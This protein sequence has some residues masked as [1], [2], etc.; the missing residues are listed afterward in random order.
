M[1]PNVVRTMRKVI[2][3]NWDRCAPVPGMPLIHFGFIATAS[4][5]LRAGRYQ[6][7]TVSD[8]GLRVWIDG[9]KVIEDW[10][11]HSR[12]R[13]VAEIDVAEGNHPIRIEYFQ[14]GGGARIRFSLNPVAPTSI[15]SPAAD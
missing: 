1:G 7:D 8:D 15:S 2:D 13:R 5:F 12:I 3:F 6:V 9:Q 10:T 11:E 14:M 4:P